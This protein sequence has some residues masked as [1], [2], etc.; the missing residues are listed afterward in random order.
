MDVGI[1]ITRKGAMNTFV[2]IYAQQRI[3]IPD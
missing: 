3:A 1:G 2:L